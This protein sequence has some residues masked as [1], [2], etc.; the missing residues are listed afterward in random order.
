MKDSA[1]GYKFRR[2]LKSNWQDK[3]LVVV[4]LIF[5]ALQIGI[6]DQLKQLPGPLYGGDYYYHLG[7]INHLSSGGSIFENSQAAG[8]Y[9]WVPPLYHLTIV[10]I[11]RISGLNLINTIFYSNILFTPIIGIL[12]YLLGLVFLKKRTLALAVASYSLATGSLYYYYHAARTITTLLFLL[13]LF[14]SYQKDELRFNI[15]AGIS[16]GLVMLSH[17]SAGIAASFLLALYFIYMT[18]FQYSGFRKP[19]FDQVKK[20][21]K[22]NLIYFSTVFGIGFAIGLIY[23]F[24]PIFMLHLAVK[25]RLQDFN[26]AV[27]DTFYQQLKYII[28][29]L[30]WMFIPKFTS[31]L[32]LIIGIMFDVGFVG[33]I[34]IRKRSQEIRFLLFLF[35]DMVLGYGHIIISEPLL[36]TNLTPSS[37]GGYPSSVFM[38]LVPFIGII[39]L[40][41]TLS[42]TIKSIKKYSEHIF[43]IFFIIILSV[44]A[45]GYTASKTKSPYYENAKQPMPQYLDDISG[46]V[47]QNTNVDDVFLSDNEDAFMLNAL[48]GRKLL[49]SRRAHFGMFVDVDERYID[50]AVILHGDDDSKRAE[51]LKKDN[52]KY[53]FW[54]YRWLSNVYQFDNN[55][56][57]VGI[58]DPLLIIDKDD[59]EKTLQT[60]NISYQKL[61]T[62]LDPALRGDEYRQYDALLVQ[63]SLNITHP[64]SDELDKYLI[65]EKTFYYQGLEAAKIYS[66]NLPSRN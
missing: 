17:T 15:L 19:D 25:N 32:S 39:I 6:V 8:G 49:A 55:G 16:Y 34:F 11:S 60:Y 26:Y 10:A 31:A 2:F 52:V 27:V 44:G 58:S 1:P 33:M 53:L 9:P 3:A 59:Y 62:W 30:A 21:L 18:F 43:I 28:G 42:G 12:S 50:A 35:A 40:L 48:T 46:W 41:N 66:I 56:Q 65:L 14:Y 20:N 47:K 37:L 61:H 23:W 24:I 4:I 29:S 7:M 38:M 54:H 51:L 45:L 5:L 13:L 57:I 64:W 63:P 22:R 36:H